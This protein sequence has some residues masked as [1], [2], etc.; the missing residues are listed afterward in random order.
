MTQYLPT[1]IITEDLFRTYAPIEDATEIKKF[2]RYIVLAQQTY[3]KPI[4]GEFLLAELVEQVKSNSL[5]DINSD[6]I[7]EVA[8]LL[9]SYA[10]YQGYPFVWASILNKGVTVRS[11]ENSQAITVKDIGQLKKWLLDT[12]NIQQKQLI[13]YLKKCKESYPLWRPIDCGCSE[14]DTGSDRVNF[15]SGFYFPKH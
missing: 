3:I 6:L 2:V 10:V 11:S 12:I 15:N 7:I 13:D 14:S 8:P 4:L 5:T 9:S 1:P